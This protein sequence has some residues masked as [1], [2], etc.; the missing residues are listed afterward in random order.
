MRENNDVSLDKATL[1]DKV[2]RLL[3]NMIIDGRIL[4][5]SRLREEHIARQFDV[6]ATPV[7]EAFKRLASD[8]FIEIIPYHGA[9]VRGIDE[10]E[11]EDV[12]KCRL[13]L[14]M[15]ALKEAID[16][17]DAKNIAAL[18]A[19]VDKQENDSDLFDVSVTN[20]KFHDIIYRVAGNRTIYTLIE[21]L[22]SVLARDMKY[23]ASDEK[24]RVDI[25]KEHKKVLQAICDRNLEAAQQ[26]MTEH[27]LNGKTYIEKKK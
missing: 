26:A 13:A 2:Y 18:K 11:I 10:K 27:I 15:L 24:R 8:G 7:R 9:V 3:V 14:E 20:Q 5:E 1:S 22:N 12:Y 16:K 23:S 19:I 25:C 4:P 6:S 17:F 21:S